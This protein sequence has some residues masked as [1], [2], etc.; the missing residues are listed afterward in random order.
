M[1]ENAESGNEGLPCY[2]SSITSIISGDGSVYLCCRLN[3]YD[4]LQPSG[5][6]KNQTFHEIWN[7]SERKKQLEMIKD[8]EFCGKNCPQCRVSKYN[9]L[10]ERLLTTKSVHFI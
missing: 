9:Q 5:N 10:F 7:G 3:I 8:R 1:K 4:W 2:A 6:I